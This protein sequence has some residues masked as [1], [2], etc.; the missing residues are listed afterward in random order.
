MDVYIDEPLI[1]PSLPAP[2]TAPFPELIPSQFQ[3]VHYAIDEEDQRS[4]MRQQH[5]EA[6]DKRA[7]NCAAMLVSDS[8]S[9]GVTLTPPQWIQ[10]DMWVFPSL[11]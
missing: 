11:I 8:K 7:K 1:P 3:Y 6:M 4:H 5:R 2:Y 10:C 9:L